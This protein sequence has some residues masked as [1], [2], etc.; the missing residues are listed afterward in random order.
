ME[1]DTLALFE[2]ELQDDEVRI[3]SEKHYQIVEPEQMTVEDLQRY[4]LRPVD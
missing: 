2:F 4:R 1:N 3:V